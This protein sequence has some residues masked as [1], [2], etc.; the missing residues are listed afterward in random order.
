[1]L[2]PHA[3]KFLNLLILFCWD[4]DRLVIM[5]RKAPGYKRSVTLIDF[6]LLPALLLKNRGR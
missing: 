2:I 4:M 1:M 5:M 3:Y 6:D